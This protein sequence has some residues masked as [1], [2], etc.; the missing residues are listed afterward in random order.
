MEKS[1]VNIWLNPPPTYVDKHE[2]FANPSPLVATWFMNA[3]LIKK[4][5]LGIDIN[6]CYCPII[7][8]IKK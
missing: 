8:Y 7:Y 5:I 2:H 4:L 6:K 1:Y 3:P